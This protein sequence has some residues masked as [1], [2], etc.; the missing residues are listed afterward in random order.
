MLLVAFVI[1]FD[2]PITLHLNHQKG[3]VKNDANNIDQNSF[4][5]F[6]ELACRIEW[7][8]MRV[9]SAQKNVIYSRL[10]NNPF[11]TLKISD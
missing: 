2:I 10:V 8:S 1:I 3:H 4:K 11:K 9:C 5:L 6:D 7:H